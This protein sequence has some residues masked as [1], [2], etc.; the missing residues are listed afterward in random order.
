MTTAAILKLPSELILTVFELQ[1]SISEV[2]SLAS[3]CKAFRELWLTHHTFITNVVLPRQIICYGDAL[4]LAQ[5]QADLQTSQYNDSINRVK[6]ELSALEL[7]QQ[8]ENRR[9]WKGGNLISDPT[10]RKAVLFQRI[11]K[12][13]NILRKYEE[14]N[15]LAGHGGQIDQ[16]QLHLRHIRRLCYNAQEISIVVED[17]IDAVLRNARR[18][19][20]Y[21]QAVLDAT[22]PCLVHP[23]K[24][25]LPYEIKRASQC[26]YHIRL[27]ILGIFNKNVDNLCHEL[28]EN[29]PFAKLYAID[30]WFCYFFPSSGASKSIQALGI[31]K[32][33]KYDWRANERSVSMT[34][35]WSEARKR[36]ATLYDIRQKNFYEIYSIHSLVGIFGALDRCNAGGSSVLGPCTEKRADQDLWDCHLQIVNKNQCTW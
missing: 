14:L 11:R 20:T 34:P 17:Y 29:M 32:P 35:E 24:Y 21:N 6:S 7:T 27:R 2:L 36:V 4:V 28:E 22:P 31:H 25:A 10:I 33:P 19:K 1:S 30:S 8:D 15:S 26:A 18:P 5:A 3:S 9:V 12:A 13:K 16:Y 23:K